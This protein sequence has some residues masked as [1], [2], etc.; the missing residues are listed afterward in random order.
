MEKTSEGKLLEL[1][2]RVL[3]DDD[4]C[5]YVTIDAAYLVGQAKD[6]QNSVIDRATEVFHSSFLDGPIEICLAES[7]FPPERR[8]YPN[9]AVDW[10]QLLIENEVPPELICSFRFPEGPV[11][12]TGT[13]MIGLVEYA[14]ERGW[15]D[16]LLIAAPFHQL[17]SFL[18]A[19]MATKKVGY[20][21][22]IWNLPGSP[23]PWT[24]SA[25]HSQGV[26]SGRRSEF[27]HAELE[28]VLT[29][30]A[31]GDIATVDE[32]LEYLNW[33]VSR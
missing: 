29:Y 16:I 25:V 5:R 30:S 26:Q 13:E 20:P 19:V 28:K 32:G 14:K 18:S 12:H 23:M 24:E 8:K 9:F 33:R 22:R 11:E 6:N 31:R 1:A 17:R 4:P 21:L 10:R 27:I 7:R 15:R 2:T 3:T